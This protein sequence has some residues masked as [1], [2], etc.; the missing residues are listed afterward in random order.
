MTPSSVYS[1]AKRQDDGE[2]DALVTHEPRRLQKRMGLDTAAPG[3]AV[4]RASLPGGATIIA[5][6]AGPTQK[7][8]R[9]DHVK[10][11]A[12]RTYGGSGC[13]S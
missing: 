9:P 5:S 11:E 13:R 2:L 8:P 12:L 6:K 3:A 1:I 10:T 7:I 4:R